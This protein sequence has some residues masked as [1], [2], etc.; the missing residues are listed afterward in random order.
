[1]FFSLNIDKTVTTICL[2]KLVYSLEYAIHFKNSEK[3]HEYFRRICNIS[4]FTKFDVLL[5]E[6]CCLQHYIKKKISFQ[7]GKYAREN[8]PCLETSKNFLFPNTCLSQEPFSLIRCFLEESV[9]KWI[10]NLKKFIFHSGVLFSKDI[11][12]KFPY[13]WFMQNRGSGDP[14][15]VGFSCDLEGVVPKGC[16][17]N[18]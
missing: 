18:S 5:A 13:L 7:A 12:Y 14:F 10:L 6:P 4:P 1:M 3:N 11:I 17:Q 16:P 15:L 9:R 8:T 2:C